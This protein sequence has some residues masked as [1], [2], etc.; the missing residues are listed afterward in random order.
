[1]K[2]FFEIFRSGNYPQGTFSEEDIAAIAENYDSSWLEAPITLDHGWGGPAY[3]W[4]EQLKAEGGRLLASFKDVSDQLTALVAKKA[5][6]RHSVE[7]YNDLNGKGPYLRALSMLGALDPAVKGMQPIEFSSFSEKFPDGESSEIEFDEPI[8]AVETE[9]QTFS[10]ADMDE[11]KGT[12]T[13]YKEQLDTL[14]EE[15]EK[16]ETA[17]KDFKG[18]NE[19]IKFDRRKQ[20]FK[21]FLGEQ[22]ISGKLPPKLIGQAVDLFSHLDGLKAEED[23]KTPLTLLKEFITGLPEIDFEEQAKKNDQPEDLGTHELAAAA[24]K[25]QKAQNED[26][27]IITLGQAI[28]YIKTKKTN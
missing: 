13:S 22:S 10:Q 2:Q 6:K 28:K 5:Y 8:S 25:Y 4:I 1:M 15:L 19:R 16:A 21:T 27:N 12:L 26:G 14:A 9:E 18:E 17:T 7:I 24:A 3:G 23:E 20:D 11:V